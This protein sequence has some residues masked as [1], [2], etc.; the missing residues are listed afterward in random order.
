MIAA[1]TKAG[2]IPVCLIIL[3]AVTATVSSCSTGLF[4]S[5]SDNGSTPVKPS[6]QISQLPAPSLEIRTFQAQ[7]KR[8]KLGETTTLSWDI[9][10][11]ISFTIDPPIGPVSGN[12]GSAVVTPPGTTLYT[13]KATDGNNEVTSRFLVITESIEGSILWQ[14]PMTDNS[15]ELLPPEGWVFYPNKKVSWVIRDSYKYPNTEDSELCEQIGTIVNNSDVWTM[16]EVTLDKSKIADSILPGQT[17]TYTT[18]VNCQFYT[19]KWKWQVRH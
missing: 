6:P 18:S 10:G 11:A 13:L 8:I 9:A 12:T 1:W 5:F 2:L 4:P 14:A 17:Y 15:T 3:L 19:L 16:S 7:P